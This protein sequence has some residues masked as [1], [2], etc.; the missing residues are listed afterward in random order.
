MIKL[1]IYKYNGHRNTVNKKLANG[2]DFVGVFRDTTDLTTPIV[3]I[4]SN[5][6]I[7]QNY[8]YVDE[9]KRYY[10]I[11]SVRYIMG[12]KVELHLKVDVL[13]TY[14]QQILNAT[15]TVNESE[16][17]DVYSSNRTSVYNRKPKF[18][19]VEF[20]N[21]NLFDETG[22]IIMI[23]VKGTRTETTN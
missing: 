7:T 15:A 23:T 4:R 16:N 17:P 11:Q 9:F 1:T 5:T 10:F 6:P 19:K 22:S 8:V 20:P 18:Q 12:D 21:K 14:E 13:K 3:I 2:T